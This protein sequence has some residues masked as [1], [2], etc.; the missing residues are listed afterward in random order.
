MG[1]RQA[2]VSLLSRS[3]LC[4]RHGR[5]ASVQDDA[6]FSWRYADNLASP[7]QPGVERRGVHEKATPIFSGPSSSRSP[8]W[9]RLN[10]EIF[11]T[12]LGLALLTV[13]L[14][15]FYALVGN[16]ARSW[17]AAAAAAT[18]TLELFP[19]FR[20]LRHRWTRN[21]IADLPGHRKLRADGQRHAADGA[22]LSALT[23]NESDGRAGDAE[24][25]WI[26]SSSWRRSWRCMRH[27]RSDVRRPALAAVAPRGS[28]THNLWVSLTSKLAFY[29]PCYPIV[30]TRRSKASRR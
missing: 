10:M 22:I 14:G 11:A 13:T 5:C 27:S 30:F 28:S 29:G 4:P 26:P 7:Y 20:G 16:L 17:L 6:Y 23:R 25:A 3:R 21:P 15:V 9:L 24:R 2:R 18:L 8:H 19:A 12:W 1:G